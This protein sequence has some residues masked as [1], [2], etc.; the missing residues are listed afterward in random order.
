[1]TKYAGLGLRPIGRDLTAMRI[2]TSVRT[3]RERAGWSTGA[4]ALRVGIA[5]EVVSDI[6]DGARL[7]TIELLYRLAVALEVPPGDL[8]PAPDE[9]PRIDVHL[10]VTDW[11]DS[12]AAQVIGGGPGNPTQTYLFELPPGESDGGFEEHPGDELLV[13][14]EG[15]V[16]CSALGRPDRVVRAGQSVEI[17]T[18]LP[19]GVR[20]GD[21]GS[22]R[23]L[24]V[25]T[26]ASDD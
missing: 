8:L 17:D 4:F 26:D 1:M 15:E 11:P 24:L 2:G 22:A 10:P 12:P 9:H 25:C 3:V 23:F 21:S 5:Q 20:A 19:H 18:A 13:V 14:M 6:E 16:V 7:P